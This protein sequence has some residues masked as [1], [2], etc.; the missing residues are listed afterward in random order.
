MIGGILGKKVG[1]TQIYTPEGEAIPVTVIKAGPCVVL[2]VKTE[3]RDGYRAVQ[4]GLIE[5]KVKEKRLTKPLAGHLAKAGAPP[6]KF[7][8][9][10]ELLNKGEEV[11][12]GDKISVAIFAEEKAVDVIGTSKGRGFA[13][14]F[15]RWNFRGGRNSHGSM[16]HR[17]PGS[18]GASAFP[19]RVFK[20]KKLPGRMGGRRVTVKNLKIVKVDEEKNLLLVKGAVPGAPGGYLIIRKPKGRE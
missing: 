3:E 8:R 9:E 19:S 17:A 18:I 7:I 12:P 16:F 5:D 13:G 15:K 2:Q 20:G 10:V 1:M 11:K 4:I 6:V 14:V